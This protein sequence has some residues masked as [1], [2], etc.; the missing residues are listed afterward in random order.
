MPSRHA[1]VIAVCL[2][3]VMPL[4]GQQ[5]SREQERLSALVGRWQTELEIKATAG[6]PAMKVSGTEEC[7]WFVNIHVVCRN[8][9]KADAGSYSAIRLFSHHA[10]SK[11]YSVYT[12]DS[13]GAALV[14]YGQ[15]AGE[16]WTFTAEAGESKSRLV[17]KMGPAAYE[18][19]SEFSV[20]GGDWTP[21][22]TMKATRAE[23]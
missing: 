6:S 22:S 20:R 4:A 19:T 5:R 11:L 17:I 13:A 2:G 14:A 15:I 18:G 8:D 16:T 7:A 23:R 1:M 12:I 3:L 9:A 21:V 10:P